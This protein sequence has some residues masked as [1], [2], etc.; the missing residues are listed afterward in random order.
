L[1]SVVST[2]AWYEKK[3]A[4]FSDAI[5]CVRQLLW[6]ES[7]FYMSAQKDDIVKLPREQLQLL[8]QA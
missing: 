7:S 8:Q 5:A 2:A 6:Q 3:H 1:L 4:T